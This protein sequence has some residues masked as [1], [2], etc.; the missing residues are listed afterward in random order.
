MQLITTTDT[1]AEA[2]RRF[3]RQP[4][5]AVDT[6]F[7]R[8]QTYYPILCLIQMASPEEELLVDTFVA[9]RKVHPDLAMVIALHCKHKR[10]CIVC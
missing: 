4:Y 8:E 5:V 6:E 1:L 2:C 9:L 3:R 10:W 7:M